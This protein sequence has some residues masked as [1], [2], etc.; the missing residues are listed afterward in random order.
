M[1]ARVDASL[2]FLQGV[3]EDLLISLP[4]S[5]RSV[6]LSKWS[7]FIYLR[8]HVATH[9]VLQVTILDPPG[10]LSGRKSPLIL[11]ELHH[12]EFGQAEA[13]GYMASGLTAINQ[14]EIVAFCSINE[15]KI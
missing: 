4:P 3:S 15:N 1:P 10:P 5:E 7:F 13:Q 6:G 12:L 9:S 11:G 14:C 2:S 8:Q